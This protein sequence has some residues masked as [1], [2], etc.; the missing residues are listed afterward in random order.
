MSLKLSPESGNAWWFHSELTYAQELIDLPPLPTKNVI[1]WIPFGTHDVA[2]LEAAF[3]AYSKNEHAID[4]EYLKKDELEAPDRFVKVK[5]D[6]R[7]YLK[8]DLERMRMGPIFWQGEEYFIRR[9]DHSLH[10][11]INNIIL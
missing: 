10:F 3:T 1:Q 5:C 4:E 2:Q 7:Q 11:F 9:Y 6:T 8:V